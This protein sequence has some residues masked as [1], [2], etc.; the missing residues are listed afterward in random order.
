MNKEEGKEEKD[1]R[2]QVLSIRAMQIVS[3]RCHLQ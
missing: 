3:I 2:T 1:R